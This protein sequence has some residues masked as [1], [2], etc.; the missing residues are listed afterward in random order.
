[1]RIHHVGYAVHDLE[2]AT[3][4]FVALGYRCEGGPMA[5]VP[6]KIRVQFVERDGYRVEL[7]APLNGPD[8][9][10][11]VT[12]LLE[13]IG[14]TAYHLAYEVDDVEG[15][16]GRLVGLG[17]RVIEE[18]SVAP[19]VGGR[20]AAFLMHPEVGLVEVLGPLQALAP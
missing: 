14:P 7:I 2:A 15:E 4:G 8:T 16:I 9:P 17:Y 11:P 13:H 12:G 5:D 19:A 18:P 20:D 1:M 10:S 6:R 3:E